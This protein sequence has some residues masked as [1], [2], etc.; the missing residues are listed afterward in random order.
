MLTT[1]RAGL[2]WL[3]RGVAKLLSSSDPGFWGQLSSI[4]G[5]S[6]SPQPCHSSLRTPGLALALITSGAR[7]VSIFAVLD[8][9]LE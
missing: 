3:P 4:F 1:R 9:A 5:R 6:P 8:L 7:S 2:T